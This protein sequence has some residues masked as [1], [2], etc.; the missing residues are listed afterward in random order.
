MSS[1]CAVIANLTSKA[2]AKPTS[3]KLTFLVCSLESRV[4]SS[5]AEIK[6]RRKEVS[7]IYSQIQ[8]HLQCRGKLKRLRI[9]VISRRLAA[10]WRQINGS[11]ERG[12]F[13]GST[14][15][16]AH[17]RKA[18]ARLEFELMHSSCAR[19]WQAA[20]RKAS[21]R[22]N[23]KRRRRARNFWLQ[24]ACLGRQTGALSLKAESIASGCEQ[25]AATPTQKLK[26]SFC[27]PFVVLEHFEVRCLLARLASCWVGI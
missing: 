11:C 22:R 3:K 10:D 24:F 18:E 1:L 15:S 25:D 26:A 16:E 5:W 12:A 7:G 13:F 17:E 14:L 21:F 19:R 27:R 2:V 8:V 6:P 4:E 23:L 20:T 9:D